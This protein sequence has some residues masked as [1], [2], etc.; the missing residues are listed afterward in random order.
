[1]VLGI[2]GASIYTIR[3]PVAVGVGVE[4]AAS[5]LPR[6]GLLGIVGTIVDTIWSPVAVAIGL[7]RP[8]TAV[9]AIRY[10]VPIAVGDIGGA[11]SDAAAANPRSGLSCVVRA[12]IEAIRYSVPIAVC[13]IGGAVG[14]AATTNAR[15]GRL[16]WVVRAV[17]YAIRVPVAVRVDSNHAAA[18]GGEHQQR[19]AIALILARS[20]AVVV[21][22]DVGDAAATLTSH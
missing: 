22:I 11:V 19:I 8:G 15:T 1:M 18:D 7:G 12:F 16:S 9:E 13:D 10:S 2:E 4:R 21:R 5:T 14:D 6:A 17:V 3:V 20:N